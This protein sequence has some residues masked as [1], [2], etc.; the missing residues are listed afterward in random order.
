MPATTACSSHCVPLLPTHCST[1]LCSIMDIS[2]DSNALTMSMN[3]SNAG[4][5]SFEQSIAVNISCTSMLY[6]HSVSPPYIVA[7]HT[8]IA[9]I[10]ETA[11]G[12][13][14]QVAFHFDFDRLVS[15]SG[16]APMLVPTHTSAHT[17]PLPDARP[18][19]ALAH[20]AYLRHSGQFPRTIAISN[21][22]KF[23][24]LY[25]TYIRMGVNPPIELITRSTS[26]DPQ[27]IPFRPD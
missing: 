13:L 2:F 9:P 5:N 17:T 18:R 22:S 20:R 23:L 26:P 8:T 21:A 25:Y 16:F 4:I 27:T 15:G 10:P 7:C 24:Y 1:L 6:I 12:P 11:D 19:A 14:L 3:C